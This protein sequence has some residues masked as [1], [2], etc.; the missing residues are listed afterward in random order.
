MSELIHDKIVKE[1]LRE[2]VATP[3]KNSIFSSTILDNY[4]VDINNKVRLLLKSGATIDDISKFYSGEFVETISKAL[5]DNYDFNTELYK[6]TYEELTNFLDEGRDYSDLLTQI[7]EDEL[8]LNEIF[9]RIVEEKEKVAITSSKQLQELT[10][11]YEI[12]GYYEEDEKEVK[13]TKKEAQEIAKNQINET[14]ISAMS[15]RYSKALENILKAGGNY[16]E[17]LKLKPSFFYLPENW[18]GSLVTNQYTSIC[19]AVKNVFYLDDLRAIAKDIG[20]PYS[21]LIDIKLSGK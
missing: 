20:A 3:E 10:N 7:Y 15:F 17:L 5:T 16:E 18:K 8:Y 11:I 19:S 6:K 2:I 4:L 21:L 1:L 12:Y 13:P 14:F 9:V